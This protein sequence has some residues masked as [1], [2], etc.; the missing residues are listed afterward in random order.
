MMRGN[1]TELGELAQT[2]KSRS[3]DAGDKHLVVKTIV[4]DD[5]V[6]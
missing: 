4:D 1:D 3:E 5:H 6:G 2:T